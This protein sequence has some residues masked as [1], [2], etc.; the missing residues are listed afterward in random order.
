MKPIQHLKNNFIFK[1]LSF[2]GVTTSLKLVIALGAQK[3]VALW[4]GASGLA[5]IANFRNLLELFR[6]FSSVGAHN[7]I[8]SYTA[9]E[10]SQKHQKAFL[11]SVLSLFGTAS[12]GLIA[13]VLWQSDW[14]SVQVF[15]SRSYD[16][17]VQ[18]SAVI[19]PLMA[20]NVL[21]ESILSGRKAYKPVAL[22]QLLSY[23]VATILMVVLLYYYGIQGALLAFLFRPIFSLVF[24]CVHIRKQLPNLKLMHSFRIE[25]SKVKFLL[26][27]IGMSIISVGF[28]NLIEIWI[29]RLITQEIN[30]EHAGLWTA[31]NNISA[32]Y[33]MFIFSVFTIYV[34]PKFSE[35]STVNFNLGAESV[36]ILTTLLPFV[37]TGMLLVYFLRFEIIQVLYHQDF[38]AIA[39]LFKWQL[40]ADWLRVIFLIF[41]YY[42]VAK[43]R[44]T[45]FFVV[46]FF[47]CVT[48]VGL[49]YQLVDTYGIE[50]IMMANTFRFVGCLFLVI[51]LLRKSLR[52]G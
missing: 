18:L 39:P 19:I 36:K 41:S 28:V 5:L 20:L 33:F 3:L 8:I 10:Q 23:S 45:D 14:L 40:L 25:F 9:S 52:N 30:L 24:F 26:P 1:L 31:M 51:F 11:H 12:V 46:E 32:N 47:S 44:L 29:R 38:I 2:N 48:F 7:A 15:D 21:L 4:L 37:S 22:I 13:L 49:S 50:G 43:K 35:K 17:L 6:S 27:F 16:T 42:L 34:L